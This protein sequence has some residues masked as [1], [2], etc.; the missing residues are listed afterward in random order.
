M[1]ILVVEDDSGLREALAAIL[2]ES[3]YSV[4]E[5]ENGEEGLYLASQDIYDLLILDIMLP[6]LSGLEIVKTLRRQGNPVPVLLLTARDSVEDRVRGFDHG[7]D[8]Y[9]IKPFA[10]PELLARVK[11]LIRRKGN[12]AHENDLHWG[13]LR[14]DSKLREAFCRDKA[15]GLTAKEYELLEFLMLN[16]GQLLSKEQILDRIWGF[17]SDTSLGIVDVYMHYLRK[18]L[19]PQQLDNLIQTVRGA[20]FI[21][22]GTNDV[23]KDTQKTDGN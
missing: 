6:E 19:A 1:R 23:S 10:T 11:A 22:K 18:K 20:G 5:A 16:R 14:L 9:L 7:A 13:M 8:D 4:D 17:E 15:L 3:Q 2:R 12:F 21:L